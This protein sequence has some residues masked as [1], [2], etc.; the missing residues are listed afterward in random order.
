MDNRIIKAKVI[1]AWAS[2]N[3]SGKNEGKI[4]QVFMNAVNEE[5][6]AVYD[7]MVVVSS[8]KEIVKM[9]ETADKNISMP[10]I[11]PVEIRILPPKKNKKVKKNKK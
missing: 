2:Y 7:L 8:R 6:Y 4:S 1:K 3:M 5:R 11:V 9:Y 10:K